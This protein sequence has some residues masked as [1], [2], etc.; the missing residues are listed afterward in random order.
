MP[1][2]DVTINGG[3][4][5][6]AN[7]SGI[8]SCVPI[9]GTA[10]TTLSGPFVKV[11]DTCGAVT[12]SS[13]CGA[14]IDLGLNAGT[15]CAVPAGASVKIRFRTFHDDVTSVKLRLYDLN[16]ASQQI[17]AMS[18]AASDNVNLPQT[19]RFLERPSVLLQVGRRLR[20]TG[21]ISAVFCTS[22]A[23]ADSFDGGGA[24]N[25]EAQA[26]ITS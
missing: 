24:S 11:T 17:V 2:A 25:R 4:A 6:A 5:P 20:D 19:W 21:E 7:G 9:G 13:I 1:Y 18:R 15:D 12:R 8:F 10:V 3:A 22:G 26:D 14:D 23:R 16:T